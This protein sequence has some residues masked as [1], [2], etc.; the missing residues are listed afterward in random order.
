MKRQRASRRGVL[1]LI[2]LSLLVLFVLIAVTFVVVATQYTSAAKAYS[3]H[4]LK[5]D[6]PSKELD[7]AVYML[8]RGTRDPSDLLYRHNLLR[9]LYG[10]DGF[11]A[12]I[13]AVSPE[14][15]GEFL[16]VPFRVVTPPTTA[17]TVDYYS[18][19]VLTLIDGQGRGHSTRVVRCS[20]VGAAPLAQGYIVVE[21]FEDLA[22]YG[23]GVY[24]SFLPRP[25][26]RFVVNGKPFNGTGDGYNPTTGKLDWKFQELPIIPEPE[27]ALM[28]NLRA[29]RAWLRAWVIATR[30]GMRWITRITFWPGFLPQSRMAT[31]GWTRTIL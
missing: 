17:K 26:N 19:S 31:L 22:G 20:S 15:G 8:L 3:R 14:G 24:T 16:R 27:V 10:V 18:G 4:E 21:A 25:G 6:D 13:L 1:L 11:R 29:Q 28:P 5:G 7:A 2:V 23:N 9:D 30:A 12:Q